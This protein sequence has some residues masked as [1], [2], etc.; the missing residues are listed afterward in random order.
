MQV[1]KLK[2]VVIVALT[3][4][5]LSQYSAMSVKAINNYN[6][7]QNV[8]VSKY[9]AGNLEFKE[10]NENYM[11]YISYENGE[12][13]LYQESIN[14]RNVYSK[15][16]KV[17]DDGTKSLYKEINSNILGNG[18]VE[19]EEEFNDGTVEKSSLK[20]DVEETDNDEGDV[21]YLEPAKLLSG[22]KYIRTDKR[23]IS[24]V[25]KKVSI[26]A[27]SAAIAAVCPGLVAAV[28]AKI[29]V[30]AAATGAGVAALP[31]YI[32]ETRKVYRTGGRTSKVYTRFEGKFYLDARRSQ[33][34]GSATYSQRG[35]H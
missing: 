26:A 1:K 24:L 17:R 20:V 5:L 34:I 19:S 23:G 6:S 18:V 4:V 14:G 22:K 25:G 9:A 31:N 2:K 11:E 21:R 10:I 30:A 8:N 35:Y 27:V 28:A 3:V 12:K 29:I 33:Y 16:F 13:L 32:Y 7:V 15:V